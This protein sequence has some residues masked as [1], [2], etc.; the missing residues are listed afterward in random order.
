MTKV[1]SNGVFGF[2]CSMS[3]AAEADPKK[4]VTEFFSAALSTDNQ[5]AATC[6]SRTAISA[7]S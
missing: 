7:Q 4:I 5:G 2:A 1:S 6:V 3:Q